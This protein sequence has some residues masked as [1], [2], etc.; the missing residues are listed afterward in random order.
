MT[1][2]VSVRVEW[3]ELPTYVPGPDSPYP[4]YA[5]MARGER[6]PYSAKSDLS[7]E[8]RP[9]RHRTVVL[10]NR[11]VRAVVLPDMGGRLYRLFDK[12]AGQ[13]AFMVPP[14]VKFQNVAWRGAWLAGGIEFNYGYHHHTVN[15]VSPVTWAVRQEPDGSAA[16]WVGCAI[17]PVE[18]R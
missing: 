14:T 3:L 7:G 4:E 2:P 13:D 18:S 8:A 17:L 16:V 10:E 5:W 12:T 15:T 9:A 6:Y 1:E 11:Y